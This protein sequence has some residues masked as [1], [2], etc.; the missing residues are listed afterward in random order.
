M[1]AVPGVKDGVRSASV[2]VLLLTFITS[3]RRRWLVWS[4]G[5]ALRAAMATTMDAVLTAEKRPA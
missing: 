3:S 5:L 1:V 2:R 4:A